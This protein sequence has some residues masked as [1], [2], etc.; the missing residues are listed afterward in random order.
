MEKRNYH[1]VLSV[2]RQERFLHYQRINLLYTEIDKQIE[3]TATQYNFKIST[4]TI[5]EQ[6]IQVNYLSVK[7]LSQTVVEKEIWQQVNKPNGVTG[8][9]MITNG[10]TIT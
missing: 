8:Y 5:I 9:L 3:G 7:L 1:Y 4:N 10:E 6:V 2:R